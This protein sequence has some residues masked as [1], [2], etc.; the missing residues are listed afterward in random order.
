MILVLS[1]MVNLVVYLA[2]GGPTAE[3]V[4]TV[5]SLFKDAKDNKICDLKSGDCDVE[6]KKSENSPVY[7]PKFQKVHL[8]LPRINPVR[9]GYVRSI[10]IM[11]NRQHQ[12]K[13]LAR[14]P[15]I[16]E[17]KDF[18]TDDECKA[19]I[20]MAKQK[21]MKKAAAAVKD[22]A[23]PSVNSHV[24][25]DQ[26]DQN[27][28]GFLSMDEVTEIYPV[29]HLLL[30]KEDIEKMY[31]EMGIKA[32]E[33]GEITY[34]ELSRVT[35]G[36]FKSYFNNLNEKRENVSVHNVEHTILWH[37]EDELLAYDDVFQDYHERLSNL[38]RIP[39]KLIEESEPLQVI[40]FMNGSFSQCQHD[41]QP[42][43]ADMPCCRYGT[44]ER[45][46]VCRFLTVM[47]FLNDVEDGELVFPLADNK[48]L[49]WDNLHR[50]TIRSC[51]K[52]TNRSLSNLV[53][54]PEKGKAIMW[55]NHYIGRDTGWSSTLDP[56]SLHGA[57]YVNKTDK[58]IAT[59]WVN[60][61]GDGV[62]ELRP[63]RAGSNWLQA[64]NIQNDIIEQMRN[65]EFIEGEEY[66][67]DSK[68]IAMDD[69]DSDSS[70]DSDE[71]HA[72]GTD[73]EKAEDITKE[74][75]IDEVGEENLKVL[76]E[77]V[78]DMKVKPQIIPTSGSSEDIVVATTLKTAT[79]QSV[80]KKESEVKDN[81]TSSNKQLKTEEHEKAGLKVS[82][83]GLKDDLDVRKTKVNADTIKDTVDKNTNTK[84]DIKDIE[85][86]NDKKIETKQSIKKDEKKEDQGEQIGLKET[87][88][89][90]SNNRNRS[91][92]DGE[93]PLGPPTRL[94]LPPP[95]VNG[96]M[97]ENRLVH[98]VL[99]LIEELSRDE[100]ELVARSLHEK[101]Q[102]ACIPLVMNPIG[103]M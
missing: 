35:F 41:S 50:D 68:L 85:D 27:L 71:N 15:P 14:H 2:S 31:E 84:E 38:T 43:Y 4:T 89:K 67:H 24:L 99:I 91:P 20:Y 101:L 7:G 92:E 73:D 60:I 81:K 79:E 77:K 49:C 94:T 90:T 98:S 30:S 69:E 64:N 56:L 65:D 57:N 21:G 47:Y 100:L 8:Q 80:D 48:T 76:K 53:I 83:K 39:T 59:T 51:S 62:D 78:D 12:F 5:T 13:T 75:A 18:L 102:L 32:N 103:P 28:D 82:G 63:W 54:K 44:T 87:E 29:K 11:K 22:I 36:N 3:D 23:I 86:S 72:K 55:Y 52:A 97:V 37:D 95:I 17:I 10:N 25:F 33:K 96:K 58:W 34:G 88:T 26:W 1:L 66:L 93:G 70:H 40:R 42:F 19:I 9:P 6:A 16:F 46:R 45:C 61:I 74:D